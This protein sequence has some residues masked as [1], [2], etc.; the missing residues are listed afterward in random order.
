MPEPTRTVFGSVYHPDGTPWAGGRVRFTL[1][2]SFSPAVQYPQASV[3][4]VVDENGDFQVDLWPN[5]EGE[6]ASFYTSRLPDGEESRWTLPLGDGSPIPLSVLRALGV[7]NRDWTKELLTEFIA[8]HPDL[9]GPPGDAGEAATVEV[10]STTTG[11]AG[12]AASVTNSGTS[13][14]AVLDFVIPRGEQGI[15]G[16]QGIQGDP[17]LQGNAATVAVGST[18]TGA[19]GTN[20]NV[21]NSGTGS[22]AVLNFTIPRG[23]QGIQGIQGPAPDYSVVLNAQTGT[24]YTLAASDIRKLVTLNN[25]GAIVLTVPTDAAV[26]WPVGEAV[27]IQQTGAGQVTVAPASGVTVNTT[28][29]KLRV[30]WSAA[31]LLKTAANTW[32]LIGDVTS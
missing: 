18:T 2:G 20:A 9:K 15:Q 31:T 13:G 10:G 25:A 32:T 16:I 14:A 1:S 28:G 12:S 26:T 22:A 27:S 29:T 30:Q 23:E 4:A 8:D 3:V 6:Q 21:T 5:E 7:I 17:G 24:A 11:P 19:A